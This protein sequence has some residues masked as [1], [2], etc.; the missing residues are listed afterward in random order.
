MK[1]RG[2][3]FL[4]G[5]LFGTSV[6]AQQA[7][8]T[9]QPSSEPVAGSPY[10]EDAYTEG[11]VWQTDHNYKA[12]L[13]YNIY[14]DQVEFKRNGHS[15]S[16]PPGVSVLKVVMGTTTLVPALYMV[17]GKPSFGFFVPLDSGRIGIMKKMTT[18]VT[19]YAPATPLQDPTPA[20][21]TRKSDTYFIRLGTEPMTEIRSIKKLIQSLPDHQ[22]EMEVFS[23]QEKISSGDAKDLAKFS[24]YYNSLGI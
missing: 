7:N 11:T 20:T 8:R 23:K 4:I 21:F 10:L 16:I 3:L 19:P 13:R 12:S 9:V 2:L 1:S 24:K 17:K 18:V 14:L 6:L 5:L 22:K 15:E